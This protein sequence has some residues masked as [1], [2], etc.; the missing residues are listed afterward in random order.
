MTEEPILGLFTIT[1]IIAIIGLV[2]PIISSAALWVRKE[3]K[4]RHQLEARAVEPYAFWKHI[5]NNPG[6]GTALEA[7]RIDVIWQRRHL[8]AVVKHVEELEAA[9]GCG[10]DDL[11]LVARKITEEDVTKAKA[12]ILWLE[13]NHIRNSEY[14]GDSTW[15]AYFAARREG[16]E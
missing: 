7:V 2:I 9:I 15:E 6:Q 4:L 13:K 14:F 11:G 10:D 1:H 16:S 12:L 3:R 5:M 8:L